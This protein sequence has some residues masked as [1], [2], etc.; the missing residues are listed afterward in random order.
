[1][2]KS[3]SVPICNRFH[4]RFHTM[5]ANIG[6][7]NHFLRGYPSFTF[8]FKGNPL[9]QGHKIL[10][11]KTRV[12]AAAHGENFVIL[13]CTILIDLKSVTD[14]WTDGETD[15]RT[16][17][18]WLRRAKREALHTVARKN[19]RLTFLTYLMALASKTTGLGLKNVGLEPVP[20]NL[21]CW[22]G[23]CHQSVCTQG[24]SH[25]DYVQLAR[26]GT[27]VG[28]LEKKESG[29]EWCSSCSA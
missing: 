12:L 4:N 27:S 19:V 16:P 24:A 17:R 10:S 3:M 15:R 6:K 9:T 2:I 14:R 25:D 26:V 23:A 18:R 5:R 22:T 7:N 20:G 29:V 13:A 8:S 1:M 11:R 28:W 21:V